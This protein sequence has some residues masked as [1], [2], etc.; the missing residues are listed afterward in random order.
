MKLNNYITAHKGFSK[1]LEDSDAMMFLK[2]NSHHNTND[3]LVATC[4]PQ[5]HCQLNS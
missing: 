2:L 1:H 4:N 5:A 3:Q